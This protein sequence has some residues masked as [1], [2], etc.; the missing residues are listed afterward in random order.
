MK[1]QSIVIII[2]LGILVIG[3]VA[4]SFGMNKSGENSMG[5]NM[6]MKTQDDVPAGMH[7]M[8]D[9]SLMGNPSTPTNQN[10]G[11]MGMMGGMDHSMMMVKS[12]RE[13]LE[14]MI[15]HH[16]EAVDTAKEVLA[17]GGSTPEIKKLAEDIIV[18]QEKEI[19]MMKGWYQAWYGEAYVADPA[20]YK[21][22]MRDLSTLSGAALDKVFLEDMIM[23]HMGAIMMAQS[24]QPYIENQEITDLT[25]AI[26][27]TQTAEIELMKRLITTLR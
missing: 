26:M 4:Y 12:E 20:D 1:N 2:G 14:G 15:P 10:D 24:V 6:D 22:M 23:H 19:A 18:A 9:G 3:A 27:E 17:R 11:G 8:P 13:F 21:P 7:R 25:K 5:M 16:Q